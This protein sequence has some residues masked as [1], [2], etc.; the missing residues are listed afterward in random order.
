MYLEVRFFFVILKD[1]SHFS[2][3]LAPGFSE[4]KAKG[5]C[6]IQWRICE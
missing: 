3:N 2:K 6:S 4:Q 5:E 1:L